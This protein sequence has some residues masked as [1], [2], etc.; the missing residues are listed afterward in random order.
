MC[1]KIN[2]VKKKKECY[3]LCT[4]FFLFVD[5]KKTSRSKVEHLLV[6]TMEFSRSCVKVNWHSGSRKGAVGT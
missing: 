1:E 2:S 6:I 5:W 4:Q 3:K